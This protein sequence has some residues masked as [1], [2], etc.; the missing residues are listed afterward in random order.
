MTVWEWCLLNTLY[1]N[2]NSVCPRLATG[3]TKVLVSHVTTW[4]PNRILQYYMLQ[5]VFFFPFLVVVGSLW[6]FN[7]L[8]T[9]I[10]YF[11]ENLSLC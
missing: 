6:K 1:V 4:V 8:E 5:V 2:V 11:K 9:Y 7:K 10:Q 3:D